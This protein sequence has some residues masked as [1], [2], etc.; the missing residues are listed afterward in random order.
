MNTDNNEDI[1]KIDPKYYVKNLN[2]QK[3]G[4][5]SEFFLMF[6]LFFIATLLSFRIFS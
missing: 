2:N 4:C 6:G 5:L 1:G 3:S